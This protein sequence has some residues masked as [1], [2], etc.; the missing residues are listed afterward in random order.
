MQGVQHVLARRFC[1]VVRLRSKNAAKD[2]VAGASA[3]VVALFLEKVDALHY[4]E[5]A[6]GYLLL[7]AKVFHGGDHACQKDDFDGDVER[8]VERVC[9]LV[10][11]SVPSQ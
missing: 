10:G 8:E 2:H 6:C 7:I 11:R 1:H 3:A 5:H 9:F 4:R